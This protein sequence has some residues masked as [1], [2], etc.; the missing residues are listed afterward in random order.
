MAMLEPRASLAGT[1]PK[2]AGKT[3]GPILAATTTRDI[4]KRI[5]AAPT[6]KLAVDTLEIG[7]ERLAQAI[8]YRPV[9][10]A[11]L[12]KHLKGVIAIA[13]EP[14]LVGAEGNRAAVRSALPD[15]STTS[16]EVYAFVETL[17]Q[18]DQIALDGGGG[19]ALTRGAVVGTDRASGPPTHTVR[20]RGGEKVL[21]RIRFVCQHNT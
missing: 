1:T 20:T 4:K 2:L 10:L 7:D 16:D 21:T 12:G 6:A 14:V 11:S 17:L 19:K 8:H 3:R 15:S 18:N 9:P 5:G 13:P